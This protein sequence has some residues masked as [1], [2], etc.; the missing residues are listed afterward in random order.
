MLTRNQSCHG[1]NVLMFAVSDLQWTASVKN[2]F[3]QN[4]NVPNTKDVEF[5]SEQQHTIKQ[6]A[7]GKQTEMIPSP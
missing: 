7:D 6:Q 2:S 1:T 3:R 5:V 4:S